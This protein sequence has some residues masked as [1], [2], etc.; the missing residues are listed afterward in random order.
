MSLTSHGECLWNIHLGSCVNTPVTGE[1][2][3][4]LMI[5]GKHLFTY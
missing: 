5:P 4:V 2:G 3:D 1:T